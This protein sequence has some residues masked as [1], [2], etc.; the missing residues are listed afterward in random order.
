MR[1]KF[2]KV[3]FDKEGIEEKMQQ[4]VNCGQ[5]GLFRRGKTVVYLYKNGSKYP[6]S[7]YPCEIKINLAENNIIPI[8]APVNNTPINKISKAEENGKSFDA[9][10]MIRILYE[11]LVINGINSKARQ[12]AGR[13]L[14]SEGYQE[15]VKN[16]SNQ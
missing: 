3:D 4:C 9:M 2:L 12:M 14:Y 10:L 11:D 5:T 13:F 1:H 16:L 8:S 6:T 7:Q 15:F